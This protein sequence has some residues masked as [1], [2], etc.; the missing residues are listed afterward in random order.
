MSVTEI[1]INCAHDKLVPIEELVPN[2]R[3]PNTH[4][5]EQIDWI[6]K[7]ISHRG[8]RA[9]L[10]VSTRS[11]FI[12][13]GHGRL[14]AALKLGLEGV[15]VDFQDFASDADEWAH[16][17]ADNRLAELATMDNTALVN[18]LTELEADEIETTGFT[19]GQFDELSKAL[20]PLEYTTEGVKGAGD[21]Q[22]EH[23]FE[24]YAATSVRQ[25]VLLYDNDEYAEICEALEKI[26]TAKSLETNTDAVTYAIHSFDE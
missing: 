21:G 18:L 16:M 7:V 14:E 2:P 9:P 10:T 17:V 19:K 22:V 23:A 8:W 20:K 6:A 5:P 26:K 24:Q 4:T 1:E 15:P 13:C 12:V 11:G 25:I 3:N